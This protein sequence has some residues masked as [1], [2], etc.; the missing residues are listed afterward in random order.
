MIPDEGAAFR[1]YWRLLAAVPCA[2]WMIPQFEKVVQ[3]Y[4]YLRHGGAE[5]E[6]AEEVAPH[7]R[8]Y[9]KFVLH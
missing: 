7:E 5:I 8:D 9:M 3:N 4:D 6:V 1:K 2:Y